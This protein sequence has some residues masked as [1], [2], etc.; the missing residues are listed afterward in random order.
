MQQQSSERPLAGRSAVVTGSGQNLGRGI[1]LALAKAGAN[2]VVNG[3]RNVGAL[4][5]V[6]TE[7]RQLGA[8]ALVAVADV[9][10][11]EAVSTMVKRALD[12]FGTVDIAISNVGIRHHQP[13]LDISIDDWKTI[14]DTNLNASFYMAKS[15]LPGMIEHKW[16]R[17]IHISGRDG[18]FPKTNRAH[19]VTC[20]AGVFALA[21]AIAVEF[22]PHGITAN[23]VAPGIIETTRDPVH[24]PN[25]E[26]EYELRRQ[27]M[28]VRR[29]GRVEDIADACLYLCSDAG[30]FVTGQVLHV[31]GG[32]FIS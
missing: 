10:D 14:L 7:I 17:I 4:E 29:L 18:F 30:G 6:A 32:E 23:A 25:F 3:R 28:P 9:S 2:V 16:G 22:G 31:N 5:A 13:F 1:A 15:V 26:R 24:Y 27:Q 11:P 21:K 8:E 12:A 20:K 19:N